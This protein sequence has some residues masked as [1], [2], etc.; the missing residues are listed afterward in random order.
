MH[1]TLL[2][3]QTSS[4]IP[5]LNSH[6]PENTRTQPCLAVRNAHPPHLYMHTNDVVPPFL[7]CYTEV[8]RRK[9]KVRMGIFSSVLDTS[10]PIWGVSS[11]R[12]S[13]D[14]FTVIISDGIPLLA[15]SMILRDQNLLAGTFRS[16]KFYL[17]SS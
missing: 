4:G 9:A 6:G 10:G 15:L 5:Y 2:I 1:C 14:A 17:F 16:A 7:P 3:A 12:A 13:D 8:L 11:T